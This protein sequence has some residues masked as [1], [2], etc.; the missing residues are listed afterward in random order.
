M[1]LHPDFKDLLAELAR[2]GVRYLVVGGYAVAFHGRPRATKDIDLWLA[3]DRDNLARA[4]EALRR[5]GAPSQIVGLV[6]ALGPSDIVY[7][8][9]PPVRVDLLRAID[10]IEDFE[11]AWSSRVEAIWDGVTVPILGRELLIRNKRASGRPRDLL[12]AEDLEHADD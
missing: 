7:M 6:A 9:S 5:F 11:A 4:A 10:G 1:N 12:D 8:G 3:G 2:D